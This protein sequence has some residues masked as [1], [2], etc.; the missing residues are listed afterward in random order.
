MPNRNPF[1]RIAPPFRHRAD[2]MAESNKSAADQPMAGPS[3]TTAR[4]TLVDTLETTPNVTAIVTRGP[5]VAARSARRRSPGTV[6]C[7]VSGHTR[8]HGVVGEEALGTPLAGGV[9]NPPVSTC[10]DMYSGQS[11]ADEQRDPEVL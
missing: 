5:S 6:V 1:P 9:A 7:T 3:D 2:Q 10:K 8:R 4:P 11:P